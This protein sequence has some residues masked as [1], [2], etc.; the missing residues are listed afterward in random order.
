MKWSEMKMFFFAWQ[1]STLIP[2][3]LDS[4]TVEV[5]AVVRF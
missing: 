4:C 1:L 5:T 3:L 2:E